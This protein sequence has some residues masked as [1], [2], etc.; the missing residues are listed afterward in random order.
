MQ[1]I[2]RLVIPHGELEKIFHPERFMPKKRRTRPPST[3]EFVVESSDDGHSDG[4]DQGQAVVPDVATAS[5]AVDPEAPVEPSTTPDSPDQTT[6]NDTIFQMISEFPTNVKNMSTLVVQRAPELP[7]KIANIPGQLYASAQGITMA[8]ANDTLQYLSQVPLEAAYEVADIPHKASHEWHQLIWV[9]LALIFTP[10]F[11]F[12]LAFFIPMNSVNDGAAANYTFAYG[13]F[14]FYVFITSLGWIETCNFAFENAKIPV[15]ARIIA[16]FL[17]LAVVMAV[18]FLLVQG[19]FGVPIF[20]LPFSLVTANLLAVLLIGPFLYLLCPEKVGPVL[21]GINRIF[22]AYWVSLLIAFAWAVGVTRTADNPLAQLI[23]TSAFAPL[24]FICKMMITAPVTTHYSPRRWMTLNF[25]I[26]VI[27]T[28]VQVS[29]YPFIISYLQMITLFVCEI[30]SLLWRFTNGIDR[31]SLW[32]SAILIAAKQQGGDG[33]TTEDDNNESG[34][35][36][37]PSWN[38]VKEITIRCIC[39]PVCDIARLNLNLREKK[40]PELQIVRTLTGETDE[41]YVSEAISSE[42]SNCNSSN[43]RK[44]QSNK[45]QS[46]KKRRQKQRRV[47]PAG[48]GGHTDIEAACE[49]A[50]ERTEEYAQQQ[51]QQQKS[52]SRLVPS[53]SVLE[54]GCEEERNVCVVHVMN[55]QDHQMDSDSE[56][57]LDSV[58]LQSPKIFVRKSNGIGSSGDVE[59]SPGADPPDEATATATTRPSTNDCGSGNKRGW[60]SVLEE[61]DWKQRVFYHV[62][63]SIGS[64][65]VSTVA[66]IDQQLSMT[67]VRNMQSVK[68]LD[69]SFRISNE[70]WK[71]A[72]IFGW[73]YISLML[74]MLTALSYFFFRRLEDPDGN[75]LSL[76]RVMSYIFKDHFWFL[77]LWLV[78]SGAFVCASM[79]NHFGADFSFNFVWLSCPDSMAWPVCAETVNATTATIIGGGS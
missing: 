49:I 67:M 34:R 57:D 66:R 54:L 8:A 39:A 40:C 25:V 52:R 76:S 10:V 20:P 51:Q 69:D 1:L 3:I 53:T 7:G 73:T 47:C 16:A 31:C 59:S 18:E 58:D 77:F 38:T 41:G 15:W 50:D 65:V 32:Y 48:N 79:V 35:F 74:L 33:S 2:P 24:R 23:L 71:K 46:N 28:R 56:S 42:V 4:E 45:K 62:L 29:T 12:G 36:K 37:L 44:K 63:D 78:T 30:F 61:I 17:I 22:L 55:N 9:L 6:L 43:R 13:I 5:E 72:Q 75:K 19:I 70:A 11:I 64:Q 68:H 26:D 27:F 60:L 21:G 14:A